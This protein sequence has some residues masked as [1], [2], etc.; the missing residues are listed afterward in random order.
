MDVSSRLT[1]H[2]L[3]EMA[4]IMS[5]AFVMHEHWTTLI[6]PK[7]RRKKALNRIF[8]M[9]YKVINTYGYITTITLDDMPIGYITYMDASDKAQISF[10]RVLRTGGIWSFIRFIFFLSFGEIK[11]ILSYMR[12][13]QTVRG[14]S[15]ENAVHLYMVGIVK[16]HRGKGYMSLAFHQMKDVF[17]EEGFQYI[18]LE[19]SDQS[20]IPIYKKMGF[21]LEKCIKIKKSNH[22]IYFFKL[23]I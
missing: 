21:K 4:D 16:E 5:T 22:M 8:L 13:Y 11:G 15:E 6:G 2:E 18:V 17:K 3:K 19:T 7:K 1:R 12:T 9:I 20:N 10:L 14:H 23:E